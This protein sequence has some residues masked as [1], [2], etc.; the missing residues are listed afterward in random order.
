MVLLHLW[1]KL[2]EFSQVF[3]VYFLNF[4]FAFCERKR[5]AGSHL[6]NYKKSNYKNIEEASCTVSFAGMKHNFKAASH[7]LTLRHGN[8]PYDSHI[9]QL[10]KPHWDIVTALQGQNCKRKAGTTNGKYIG[11]ARQNVKG[12]SSKLYHRQVVWSWRTCRWWGS[13]RQ[14]SRSQSTG[15]CMATNDSDW[16][17]KPEAAVLWG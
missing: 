16:G 10:V 11:Q 8:I 9:R 1:K 12:W 14:Q 13:K 15:T 4:Y 6:Y 7:V 17:T 3:K 5:I 2:N